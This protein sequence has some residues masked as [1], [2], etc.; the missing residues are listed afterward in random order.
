ME[1]VIISGKGGTGKTS[2]AAA[3]ALVLKEKKITCDCDVDAANL[4]LVLKPEIRFKSKFIGGKKAR[5]K[6]GH[7]IACGKCQEICRFSAITY[8]GCGNG[9]VD[10][11]FR[12]EEA[13]CEGCGL[14]YRFCAEDAI[15][16][17]ETVNGEYYISNTRAGTLIHAT[18]FPGEGNSGKLVA[19]LKKLAHEEA[20]KTGC[21]YIIVDGSPGIGCPVIAALSG[22]DIALVVTEANLSAFHDMERVIGVCKH[23]NINVGVLINRYD[24]NKEVSLEIEKWCVKENVPVLMKLPYDKRVVEAQVKNISIVEYDDSGQWRQMMEDILKLV[25]ETAE[26]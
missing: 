6:T 7:C 15:E 25:K 2:V 23:F 10:R 22:A 16:F 26:K 4:F 8:D 11:T 24:I 5:I 12:I 20:E 9:R 18:L 13:M 17:R 1:I 3:L 19:L 14:C 21:G